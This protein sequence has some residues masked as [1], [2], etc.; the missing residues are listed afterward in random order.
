ML[1]GN[2]RGGGPKRKISCY[3]NLKVLLV[4][5]KEKIILKSQID[6]N[7]NIVLAHNIN[8]N[9]QK[10]MLLFKQALPVTIYN[11]NKFIGKTFKSNSYFCDTC[12]SKLAPLGILT[13]IIT[14]CILARIKEKLKN[15][16]SL[17]AWEMLFCP[18]NT[19]SR[20]KEILFLLLLNSFIF[21]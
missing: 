16:I 4:G 7:F 2:E 20:R 15:K 5:E 1:Y 6:L 14:T 21:Q 17:N 18:I 11:G 13:L 12:P 10:L 19:F 3:K 9:K 8:N